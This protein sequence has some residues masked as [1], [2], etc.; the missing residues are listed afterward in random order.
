[1]V[2]VLGFGLKVEGVHLLRLWDGSLT[3]CSF[4]QGDAFLR[5]LGQV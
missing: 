4:D 1:M 5:V 3:F 2:G